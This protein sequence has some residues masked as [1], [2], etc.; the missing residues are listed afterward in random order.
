MFLFNIVM[1]CL[2][3]LR[4][5]CQAVCFKK[6][7]ILGSG[8]DL[9]D[10]KPLVTESPQTAWSVTHCMAQIQ[11]ARMLHCITDYVYNTREHNY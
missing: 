6:N 10:F 7:N 5:F 4:A 1:F 8:F 9:I 2:G 11:I 3:I